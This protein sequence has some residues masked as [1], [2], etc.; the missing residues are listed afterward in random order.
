MLVVLELTL[1]KKIKEEEKE[2]L[3]KIKNLN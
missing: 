3:T 2:L 1:P